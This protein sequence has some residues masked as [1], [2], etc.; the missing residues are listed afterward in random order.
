MCS[1][2]FA[3]ALASIS[4]PC[5][6]PAL[7]AVADLERLDLR[8]QLVGE[9]LQH[10][11]LHVEAVRADAGLAGVAV[12]AD[13]RAF[14]GR[15]D[16]G[17]VEHDERRVAAE[18][19]RELLDRVGALPH[20]RAADF[21]RAGEGEL[22]HDRASASSRRRSCEAEPV[23]TASRPLGTPARSA[24]SANASA[25]NGVC[26]AGFTTIEQ[27]AASAGPALRVSI[28]VGKFHG[29]IAAVVPT[30][31]FS[32]RMRLSFDGGGNRVAVDAAR[33]VGEPL[34]E[35]RGV[36]DLALGFGQRLALLA[37]HDQRQVVGVGEHQVVELAQDRGALL[38]GHV[39]PAAS[40]PCR[41]LRWR[42]RSRRCRTSARCRAAR[43]WRGWSRPRSRRCRHR[44]T[45][46]PRR[47]AA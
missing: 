15:V 35:R 27:P 1:S 17:I 25:E 14:D 13:H 30:G 8:D 31:C 39:A 45:G 11:A 9:G 32:A 21:G 6:T 41:R 16:V 18:F 34:D 10:A 42:A 37:G 19:E 44:S 40:A 26:V 23:S 22:A 20:Q 12:L 24:S 3:T 29:V 4:G 7:Q 47:P 46:R 36:G 28:A 43:R 33:L 5:V 38:R 2:I